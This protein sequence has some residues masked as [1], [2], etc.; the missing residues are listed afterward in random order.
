MRSR[1]MQLHRP[2]ICRS[3]GSS[4]AAGTRAYWD[5]KRRTVTCLRCYRTGSS[6]TRRPRTPPLRAGAAAE[7]PRASGLDRG[8]P[9]ASARREYLRRRSNREARIRKRHPWIGGFLALAGPPQHERAWDLG[10]RGEESVGRALERRIAQGPARILHDRRM[11]AGRGN[12]DHIAIAPRGV[13]VIDTK[14]VR[15]KVVVS[16]PLFGSPKLRIAGRDRTKFAD[17]LDRQVDAVRQA[18]LRAARED[19]PVQGV[20]CFAKADLPLLRSLQIRGHRLLHQRGLARK[21]NQA[22][23]LSA[24]QIDSLTV[25]LATAFPPG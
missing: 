7:A 23:V 3:C 12:I 1:V 2:D 11:P 14:A 21:L 18:L 9:G 8:L 13:F 5:A 20:L 22:G 24:E 4:I 15:G 19:V 25:S 17:G 6:G 16:H 10:A